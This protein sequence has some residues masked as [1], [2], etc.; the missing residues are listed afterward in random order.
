MGIALKTAETTLKLRDLSHFA[1]YAMYGMGTNGSVTLNH[2][3]GRSYSFLAVVIRESD[4]VPCALYAR[5]TETMW[6]RPLSEILHGDKWEWDA[7][8]NNLMSDLAKRL[9]EY[10]AGAK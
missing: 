10:E 5:G 1:P 8:W 2:W 7:K 9:E 4:L 3:S 6:V